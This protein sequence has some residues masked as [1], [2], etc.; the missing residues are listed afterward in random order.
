M[1]NN[2]PTHNAA[3]D[4]PLFVPIISFSEAPFRNVSLTVCVDEVDV[5]AVDAFVG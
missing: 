1:R 5:G 4:L 2:I 3:T